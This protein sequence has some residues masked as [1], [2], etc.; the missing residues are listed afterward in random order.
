M[1]DQ[2]E[3]SFDNRFDI[4][5]NP[6]PAE[7]P[8]EMGRDGHP[9]LLRTSMTTNVAVTSV[10]M[11]EGSPRT[12][13]YR[14]TNASSVAAP[15]DCVHSARKGNI[16]NESVSAQILSGCLSVWNY[17]QSFEGASYFATL[18]NNLIM[19]SGA[20]ERRIAVGEALGIGYTNAKQF[21][22]RLNHYG[23]TRKEF[24]NKIEKVNQNLR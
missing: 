20:K 16:R 7:A 12:V 8:L 15:I 17:Y 23:I 13:P 9:D 14:G 19:G 21:L 22:S 24:N 4:N 3:T 2:Y 18:H 5:P 6:K 11:T 1:L 10:I